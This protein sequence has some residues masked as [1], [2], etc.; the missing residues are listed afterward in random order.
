MYII[1]FTV[2]GER[3]RVARRR[4]GGDI[5]SDFITNTELRVFF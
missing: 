1:P 4:K 3:L 5:L 2:F